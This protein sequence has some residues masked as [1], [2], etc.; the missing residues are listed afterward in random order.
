[1]SDSKP[2]G[3][4]P[5]PHH[6]QNPDGRALKTAADLLARHG[7]TAAAEKLAAMAAPLLSEPPTEP[8]RDH[9]NAVALRALADGHKLVCRRWGSRGPWLE[10]TRSFSAMHVL[11]GE[12]WDETLSNT[13]EF[14][15]ADKV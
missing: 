8:R 6:L 7:Y 13:I 12:H 2:L 9:V 11:I 14:R 1:M 10:V 3:F 4:H 5:F 15:I